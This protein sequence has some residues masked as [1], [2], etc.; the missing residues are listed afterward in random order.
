M[1]CHRTKKLGEET[2]EEPCG[3][4]ESNHEIKVYELFRSRLGAFAGF[5]NAK[6]ER[7]ELI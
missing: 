6:Y 4:A 2:K 7:Q 3:V 1:P 5:Q